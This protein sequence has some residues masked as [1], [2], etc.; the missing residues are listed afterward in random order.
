M[1]WHGNTKKLSYMFILSSSSVYSPVFFCA[2]YYFAV[3][4]TP[5]SR[6]TREFTAITRLVAHVLIA[7]HTRVNPS[8]HA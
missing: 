2:V 7:R 4:P 5:A 1:E 3:A 6:Y 8:L